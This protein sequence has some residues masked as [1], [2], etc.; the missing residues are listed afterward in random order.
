MKKKMLIMSYSHLE[1]DPRVYRQIQAFKDK[2]DVM[3]VGYSSSNITGV[4]HHTSYSKNLNIITR[5]KYRLFRK[6]LLTEKRYEKLYWSNPLIKN[7]Y[8]KLKNF[9]FDVII[10]ND[11]N[12]LPLA[13]KVKHEAKLLFDAHEYFPRH[14]EHDQVWVK[15]YKPYNTYL[16]NKYISMA[17]K[18]I[19]V[20]EGIAEEY[21]KHFNIK[22]PEIITNAVKYHELAPT[23]INDNSIKIIHHGSAHPARRIE[24]MIEIMDYVDQ[25]FKLDLML[26]PTDENYYEKLQKMADAR[27]N[28]RIISP[29][30][31]KEIVRKVNSY[32]IGISIFPPTTFNLKNALPNKLFEFIQARL[33]IL[34]GPSKEMAKFVNSYELGIVA[35]SFEPKDIAAELNGLISMDI[36]RYK[37]N[38]HIASQELNAKY[39]EKKLINI[40][41]TLLEKE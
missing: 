41:E 26:V 2:Y 12:T 31:M 23:T 21:S 9:R 32:D 38:S 33:M 3:T 11:I 1:R 8:K 15:Y 34:I 25:R 24:K 14:Y 29:V 4:N 35:K 10:A 27:D 7:S 13:L 17:D 40:I 37:S 28:V 6:K 16:C 5:V 36:T 19:T 22:K 18:V 39:N 30:P 20:S